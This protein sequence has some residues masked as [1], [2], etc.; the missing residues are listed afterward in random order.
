MPETNKQYAIAVDLGA[1]NLRVA[2]VDRKGK[3]VEKIKVQTPRSGDDNRIIA[4]MMIGMIR[5]LIT[6]TGASIEG[7]GIAAAGPLDIEGG[8]VH[9]HNMGFDDVPIVEPL[10]DVFDA[11]ISFLN[12][13]NAAVLGES[14]FG[15]GKDFEN[16]VYLTISSGLGAGVITEGDLLLGRSGNAGEVGHMHVHVSCELLC[17]C[18]K[19]TNHWEGLASGKNI[20][21]FYKVWSE[22]EHVGTVSFHTCKTQSIFDAAK[23]GD[24]VAMRFTDEI[25]QINGQGLSNVIVA[26]DPQ[27][28]I[29]GGSV[30]EHNQ[31]LVV[32]QMVDKVDRYLDTLPEI[33]VTQFGDD[34]SLV[35][36]AAAVFE[37]NV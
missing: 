31:E 35:G 27:I 37:K 14:S 36:A 15:A 17:G 33:V 4:T 28:I 8:V 29:L 1:T 3:I 23:S 25:A 16:I 26:Y 5:D 6:E 18:K 20:P 13:T 30:V 12:D 9:N 34:V 7:I 32:K 2:L 10:M 24:E 11:P 22:K 19:G 21:R